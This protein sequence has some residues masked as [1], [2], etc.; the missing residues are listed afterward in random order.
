MRIKSLVDSV[1]LVSSLSFGAISLDSCYRHEPEIVRPIESRSPETNS[2]DPRVYYFYLS[3]GYVIEK[4]D[5]GIKCY[6][7]KEDQISE[8]KGTL[9]IIT[10]VDSK[11]D[12]C[13]KIVY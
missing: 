12:S 2:S 7:I 8:D 9:K 3:K 5:K 10:E 6:Q 13:P 1:L 11:L 4:D